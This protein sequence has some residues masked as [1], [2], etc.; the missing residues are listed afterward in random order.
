[1]WQIPSPQSS[2]QE[3]RSTSQLLLQCRSRSL[4]I[5]SCLASL[6][7]PFSFFQALPSFSVL[8]HGMMPPFRIPGFELQHSFHV[9]LLQVSL[10]ALLDSEASYTNVAV[11]LNPLH[12]SSQ[13]PYP[14]GNGLKY[15]G[16]TS[17]QPLRS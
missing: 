3:S 4:L 10:Q 6:S 13:S 16:P 11:P 8:Y 7:K 15:I 9:E 14:A 1:A 17:L 12:R 5:P 2:Q